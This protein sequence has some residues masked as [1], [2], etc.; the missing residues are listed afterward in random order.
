MLQHTHT[1]QFWSEFRERLFSFI[2]SRV[3]IQQD[4]EDVL[5]DVFT[6]IH[7]NAHQLGDINNV[8]AWVFRITRNAL[9]DQF[10]T[11]T[12]MSNSL[13]QMA[14]EEL[15][16]PP[17]Q[18]NINEAD[19]P[20]SALA[21][22]MGSLLNQLPA[23]YREAVELTELKGMTQKQ[24]AKESGLSLSGM[25]TRVQRGRV[26]LKNILLDCCN[27]ELDNRC[28]V[29]DFEPKNDCECKKC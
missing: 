7:T 10:R 25:K 19:L 14:E 18:T 8:S 4:A 13:A 23:P 21:K 16:E 6:R 22:C 17:A 28:G 20:S 2:R 12:K 1:E 24:A 26:K 3:K 5:Q 29:V 11:Q 9:T 15:Q 27:V